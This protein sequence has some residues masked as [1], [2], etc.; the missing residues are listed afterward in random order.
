MNSIIGMY[1]ALVRIYRPKYLLL[2]AMIAPAYYFLF[3][4]LAVLQ[5]QGTLMLLIPISLVYALSIASSVMLTISIYSIFNARR[6]KAAASSGVTGAA[7]A[8]VGSGLCGCSGT[9][10]ILIAN[11]FVGAGAASPSAVVGLTGFFTRYGSFIFL[12]FIAINALIII[13]QLNKISNVQKKRK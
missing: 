1:Q 11:V 13:Y 5:G 6:K 3:I 9:V 8:V 7:T 4:Y 10:P 2:N 12:A